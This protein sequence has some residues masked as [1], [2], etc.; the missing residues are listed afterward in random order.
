MPVY[1]HAGKIPHKRHTQFRN[2]AG[3]LY[4]E[5]LVGTQGFSGVSSLVYHL[6]PP[7][8]VKEKGTPYSVEPEI[9]IDKN[10]AALSFKGFEMP[11]TN[12]YLERRNTLFV[13]ND[14]R[15]GLAAV[16][17]STIDYFFKNADADEMLFVHK[18]HGWVETMYGQISF[19]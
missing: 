4:Q 16:H 15:I 10:L 3:A 18:G 11:Y 6:Y 17:D 14:L 9:A 7:V 13:N 5:E 2:H 19:E 12:D 1:H 8:I